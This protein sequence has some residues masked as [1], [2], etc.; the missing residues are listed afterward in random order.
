MRFVRS[1][2]LVLFIA[3]AVSLGVLMLWSFLA[4]A[5]LAPMPFDPAKTAANLFSS[6]WNWRAGLALLAAGAAVILLKVREMRREQ[7]IAFDNPSGEVAISMDAVEEFIRRAGAEF[8][9]VKSLVPR[10][11]AGAEGIGIAIRMDVWSGSNIPRLSEELQNAVKNKV[12]DSL[13]INV[14]GVSVSV[15]RILGDAA[16][17]GAGADEMPE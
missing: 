9:G 13:G 12:Q 17:G 11:H 8:S 2:L 4:E 15:G 16:G 6:P 7:C 3:V 14:S 1:A 5:G 10:I